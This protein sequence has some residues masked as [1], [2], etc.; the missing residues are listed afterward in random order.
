MGKGKERGKESVRSLCS[1]R[2]RS[3][4]ASRCGCA[5]RCGWSLRVWGSGLR[6]GVW[7]IRARGLGFGV[8]GIRARGLGIGFTVAAKQC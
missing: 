1:Q 8:W 2:V 5:W 7:G 6:V 4:H 3:G